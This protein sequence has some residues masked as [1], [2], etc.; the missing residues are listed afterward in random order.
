MSLRTY[1]VLSL[2]FVG[3]QGHT[4]AYNFNIGS[5]PGFPLGSTNRFA[6]ISYNFVTGGG[7]NL[8]P[9]IKINSEFMFHGI[10]VQ[11]GIVDQ[12][13]FSDVKGRLYA[14]SGNILIG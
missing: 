3:V 10:P 8:S 13:G 12:L 1:W 14:L 4:Q 2:L 11:K 5:G 6:N 9:H 7:V